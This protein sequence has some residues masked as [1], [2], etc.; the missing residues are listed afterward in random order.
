LD[1]IVK[2]KQGTSDW[3]DPRTGTEYEIQSAKY[4]GDEASEP[5]FAFLVTNHRTG[6]RASL[7]CQ[8]VEEVPRTLG[9][10][11]DKAESLIAGRSHRNRSGKRWGRG[12]RVLRRVAERAR[13]LAWAKRPETEIRTGAGTA[14]VVL[15]GGNRPVRGVG[16]PNST[17]TRRRRER[18]RR[19]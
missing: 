9:G 18:Q 7:H 14:G 11:I 6:E 2:V 1:E 10:L 16:K 15:V 8:R 12:S 5:A 4:F 13:E 19:A 17:L 3:T